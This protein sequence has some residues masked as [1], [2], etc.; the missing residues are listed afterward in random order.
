MIGSYRGLRTVD[1]AGADAGY[2]ADLI[3]FSGQKLSVACLCCLGNIEPSSLT[4]KVADIYLADEL[5]P[6][7]P[8]EELKR[9]QASGLGRGPLSTKETILSRV[10]RLQSL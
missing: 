3:R 2:R 9:G 10:K 8:K 5:E 6:I 4:R 7:A 1:H